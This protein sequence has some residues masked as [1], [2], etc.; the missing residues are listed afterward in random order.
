MTQFTHLSLLKALAAA[1]DTYKQN[2]RF[3]LTSSTVVFLILLGLGFITVGVN[4]LWFSD[5]NMF[6][7]AGVLLYILR[8]LY[9]YQLL[10]Y[11]IAIDAGQTFEWRSFFSFP[12]NNFIFFFFARLRYALIL[13]VGFLLLI[14]PGFIYMCSNLFAGYS[15]VHSLTDSLKKDA[16]ISSILTKNNRLRILLFILIALAI[17]TPLGLLSVFTLPLETLM[18]L[19]IY[20]QLMKEK[21]ES[22]KAITPILVDTMPKRKTS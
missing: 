1:W 13:V 18:M 4:S 12:S 8:E 11:S 20:K 16:T 21:E 15:I 10:T 6:T 14:I 19:E 17:Q 22:I 5:F 2:A 7:S 9:M 3:F